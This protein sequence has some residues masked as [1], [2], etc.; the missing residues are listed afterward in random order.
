MRGKDGSVAARLT[1]CLP[2][3]RRAALEEGNSSCRDAARPLSPLG[4]CQEGELRQAQWFRRGAGFALPTGARDDRGRDLARPNLSRH[5]AGDEPL[6]QLGD[7]PAE[8]DPEYPIESF[9]RGRRRALRSLRCPTE[10]HTDNFVEGYHITGIHP[11][12]IKVSSST[13]SRRW[14]RKGVCA[15]TAPTE[16]QSNLWRQGLWRGPTGPLIVPG[17]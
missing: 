17:G 12:F 14:R 13:S 6:E 11:A 7:L 2:A 5:R 3:S 16:E 9:N 4:I 15:M 10:D 1:Q 8:V